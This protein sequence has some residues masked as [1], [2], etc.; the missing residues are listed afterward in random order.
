MAVGRSLRKM[1][2]GLVLG[3][4]VCIYGEPTEDG[5][6]SKLWFGEVVDVDDAYIRTPTLTIHWWS[7]NV[8]PTGEETDYISKGT[9]IGRRWVN[10][11]EVGTKI[12]KEVR[13]LR[14]GTDVAYTHQVSANSLI[15]WGRVDQLCNKPDGGYRKLRKVSVKTLKE[16]LLRLTERNKVLPFTLKDLE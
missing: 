5:G 10:F 9:R 15:Y 14:A 13:Y 1:I 6:P 8:S 4:F 7:A 16:V 12:N 11:D 3:D 2:G